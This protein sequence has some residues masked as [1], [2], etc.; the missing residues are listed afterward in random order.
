M[1]IKHIHRRAVRTLKR[2]LL[3]QKDP[4]LEILKR[5]PRDGV[6]AEIGVWKGDFSKEILKRTSPKRLHL[7]D[8]WTFQ[9]DFP[10]R[11][12]GGH[13]A[14]KQEDMDRIFESVV[15]R[16]AGVPNVSIHRASSE[17]ALAEFPDNYFDWIYLDG[18]HDFEF[19]L[20]DL[21]MGFE[22]VR[23]GGILAGDDYGWGKKRGFPVE[24]AVQQF[25]RTQG[26]EDR[27]EVLES[28]YIIGRS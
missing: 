15:S 10:D 6:C 3:F 9:P 19:V 28:Q 26:L 5:M 20:K 7:I 16:F 2:V 18:N 13:Y 1:A 4:R 17:E 21:T 24:R 14:K 27:L 12:F 25:V 8:P 23:P 11:K 22:K